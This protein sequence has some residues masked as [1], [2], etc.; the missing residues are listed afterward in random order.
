M[1]ILQ[2]AREKPVVAGAVA[3]GISL[4]ALGV[5]CFELFAHGHPT[6]TVYNNAFYSDD[7]GKTWFVDDIGKF[8][9]F[10]HNGK[11]AYRAAV[12]RCAR[13]DPFVAYLQRFSNREKAEIKAAIAKDPDQKAHWMQAP[14]E[15]KKPGDS[16]WLRPD[17]SAT[18]AQLA[19]Y[20]RLLSPTCSDGSPATPVLPPESNADTAN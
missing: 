20:A 3:A 14:A 17:L 2:T 12:F 7:E 8:P 16:H 19:A 5:I 15:I 13:G 10:D 6:P 1:N 18:P 9:P 11:P 4:V